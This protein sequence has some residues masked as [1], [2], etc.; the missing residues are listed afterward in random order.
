MK[1]YHRTTEFRRFA[2]TL[3]L[4]SLL[5]SGGVYLWLINSWGIL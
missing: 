2:D 5:L 4:T 3:L 1:H